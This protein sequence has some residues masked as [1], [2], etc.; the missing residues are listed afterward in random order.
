MIQTV[1]N[2]CVFRSFIPMVQ[3][4]PAILLSMEIKERIEQLVKILNQA[5]REYYENDNPTLSDNEYDALMDELIHLENDHPEY[6]L[7][8]TPT[9]KVGFTTAN[10]STFAKVTHKNKMMSLGDVFSQ[11]ELRS[12]VEK[13]TDEYG[14]IEFSVECKIDGL[15]MSLWYD[16][17][18]FIQA[19]TRGDGTVGEDVSV[20]VATIASIPKTIAYMD[21]LEVRGEVYMPKLALASLNTTRSAQGLPKFAN[22]RNAAAGSIRLQDASEVSKR[23]L[24]GFWYHVPMASSMGIKTHLES[25]EWI[26]SLGFTTNSMNIKAYS[27]EQIWKRIEELTELRDQLPYDIDGVVIKVNDLS[28]QQQLGFT[29]KVPRWA[30]AY[31]FPAQQVQTTVKDIFCT[32]GRT[33]KVT[34]NAA[35]QPVQLAGSTVSFATLHN[36]DMIHLKDIRVNDQVMVRKAGDI[37]PEVVCSLPKYRDHTSTPYVFPTHCPVCGMP[38]HRFEDEA[39]HYCVNADCPARVVASIAHFA[40]RDAMNIEGLGEKRVE[41]FHQ[42]GLL[43]TLSDI[44]LLD[45]K[46]EELIHLDKFGAKSTDKLLS[47]IEHSKSNSLEKLLFGLGI[48]QVGAKQARALALHFK[49]MDALMKATRE[50][51]NA[52]NDVGEITADAICTFFED[53]QNQRLIESLKQAGLNMVYTGV[54]VES[55]PFTGLTIVLTGSLQYYDRNSATELLQTLG[56]KVTSSV[57]KSTDLV[58]Y[59]QSAGS[60]LTKANNLGIRAMSEDEFMEMVEPYR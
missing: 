19:V 23:G 12:W 40:S 37:I 33:G 10:Q 8:D 6:V 15:A 53:D 9:K 58:I 25:L 21:E 29:I 39:A 35:L 2:W 1:W 38:L 57:S 3:P 13:I 26:H 14:P 44:Y 48:R 47:A 34:P 31:K 45:Q 41:Q 27:F 28:I 18:K 20:N 55:S 59:G 50:E 36:E 49:T 42:E 22:C 17:G 46:K 52:L 11:E 60:K 5:N 54:T 56:A 7:D 24:E 30:I 32:V 4:N 51:L 43:N 16:H